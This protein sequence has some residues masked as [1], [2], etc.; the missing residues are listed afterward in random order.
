MT[1]TGATNRNYILGFSAAGFSV[2]SQAIQVSPSGAAY[3]EW[4]QEPVAQRTGEVMGTQPV[5]RLM[6]F[7]GNIAASTS[8]TIV[9][10]VSTGGGYI[11]SGTSS[12]AVNGIVSFSG[13]TMVATPSV[14]QTLTFT[15]TT[16]SGSFAFTT[17][18]P[19]VV[20]H[21][22]ASY[23]VAQ[24][25]YVQGGRQGALLPTQPKLFLFDRYGNKA[26]YDN[27]DTLYAAHNAAKAIKRENAIK[28]MPVPL[29]PGA[30]RYY[31]EVG[32]IK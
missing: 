25:P 31:K 15:A 32:L 30:E 22:D 27:I 8:A 3:L 12:S 17:T 5:L 6:D 4:I 11:E 18:T 9:A 21:T 28:G 23:L 24:S 16:A 1:F 2:N 29:H 14:S 19:L 10:S 13:L 26:I 20:R 7:D